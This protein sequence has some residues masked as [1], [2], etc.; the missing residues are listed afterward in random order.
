M[1]CCDIWTFVSEK[2]RYF[3]LIAVLDYVYLL[4]RLNMLLVNTVSSVHKISK[5]KLTFSWIRWKKYLQQFIFLN[6][7][8]A[9]NA[10]HFQWKDIS[11]VLRVHRI[12]DFEK[13]HPSD[14]SR[15]IA[16]KLF[17]MYARIRVV[18]LSFLKIRFDTSLFSLRKQLYSRQLSRDL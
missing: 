5:A 8:S 3:C 7:F 15:I 14:I 12:E 10:G 1:K 4:L 17:S 16:G 11:C 6:L 18:Y 13:T 9:R 2:L